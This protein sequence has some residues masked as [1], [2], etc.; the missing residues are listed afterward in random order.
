MR[1][2][3]TCHAAQQFAGALNR[4]LFRYYGR[5]P[6]AAMLTWDFNSRSG[7]GVP[8]SQEASRKWM[9]GLTVPELAKMQV[10]AKWLDLDLR[11]LNG[12]DEIT[13]VGEAPA[14]NTDRPASLDVEPDAILRK[15]LLHLIEDLDRPRAELVLTVMLGLVCV[16]ATQ[17][18]PRFANGWDRVD[19]TVRPGSRTSNLAKTVQTN[20][21]PVSVV[22]A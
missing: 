19:A 20:A 22:A 11:A 10:L 4:G 12:G 15:R 21:A 3:S 18:R 8:I 5:N 14:G 6:S 7:S 1:N 16:S 13:P 17:A 9:R 2:P